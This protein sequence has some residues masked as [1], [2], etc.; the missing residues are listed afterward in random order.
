MRKCSHVQKMQS[1]RKWF[2]HRHWTAN[3]TKRTKPDPDREA[4]PHVA[5]RA[6]PSCSSS[7]RR[8]VDAVA[9]GSSPRWLRRSRPQVLKEPREKGYNSLVILG[10]W[11][12]WKHRNSC[13]F[14]GAAP[15]LQSALQAFRDELCLW[16]A[17]GAKGLANLGISRGLQ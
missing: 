3:L 12:L 4:E 5:L 11:I 1:P 8:A 2:S 13:V 14:N 9:H 7:R 10:A 17:A 6:W 15:N 16:Q